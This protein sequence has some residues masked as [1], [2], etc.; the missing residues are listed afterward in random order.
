MVEEK[1]LDWGVGALKPKNVDNHSLE[2]LTQLAKD[3]VANLVF[4]DRHMHPT[5]LSM[6]FMPLILGAFSEDSKE[7]VDDVGMIYEYYKKAGP[8][9]VNGYPTFFSFGILSKHDTAIVWEK[10]EKIEKMIKEI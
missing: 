2:F 4:T 7:Y 3:I 6:V 5:D 10:V 1:P 8:T 9:S